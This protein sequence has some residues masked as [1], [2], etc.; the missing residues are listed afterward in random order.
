MDLATPRAAELA[1]L[2][3]RY[4]R[5]MDQNT[6]QLLALI[7]SQRDRARFARLPKPLTPNE[8]I[9]ALLL[10][11]EETRARFE[12]RLSGTYDDAFMNAMNGTNWSGVGV[13]THNS[14]N[15]RKAA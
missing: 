9:D 2:Y 3:A 5:F 10:M 14:D 13:T 15:R 12:R 11:G 6:R 8:F 1:E 7:S 4:V